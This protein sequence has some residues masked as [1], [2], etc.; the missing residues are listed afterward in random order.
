MSKQTLS[1]GTRPAG[2][3][4]ISIQLYGDIATAWPESRRSNYWDLACAWCPGMEELGP[5]SDPF[6]AEG[7]SAS[8][9]LDSLFLL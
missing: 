7:A 8:R 3:E 2:E 5:P 4:H 1:Y 9:A 6:V